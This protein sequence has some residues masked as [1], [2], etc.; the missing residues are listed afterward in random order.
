MAAA[1]LVPPSRPA[2]ADPDPLPRI[3][4]VGLCSDHY[5]L[6]LAAPE[7]IASLSAQ[8]TGPLSPH[9]DLAARFPANRANA[10]EMLMLD[11]DIVV[12]DDFRTFALAR[13]LER[14]GIPFVRVNTVAT[15]DGVRDTLL[16]VGRAIGREETAQA[17]VADLDARLAQ[18][19]AL[20]PPPELAAYLRPDGGS[21]GHD[22]FV[23]DVMRHAGLRNLAAE[24]GHHGWGRLTLEALVLSPPDVLVT[25]FFDMN[26]Q[27]LSGRFA[28]HAVFRRLLADTPV[29]QVPG[30]Y[31]PCGSPHLI[32]AVEA[33][34]AR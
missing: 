29:L 24:L 4:S 8:A 23:D 34:V 10:E 22:T 33:L 1:L 21:A 17:V 2:W 16:E 18:A 12:M 28:H 26:R 6:I 9:R 27:S 5:V 14:R 30:S 7:Q 20:A 3:A 11:V 15:L 32:D 13:M 25:S 19:H 31:W